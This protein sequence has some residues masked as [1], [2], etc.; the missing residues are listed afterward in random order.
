MDIHRQYKPYP[1]PERKQL[2]EEKALHALLS[3]ISEFRNWDQES[4]VEVKVNADNTASNAILVPAAQ[5]IFPATDETR[6]LFSSM[7]QIAID[8]YY[9]YS[10]VSK[11]FY[12]QAQFMKDF[13]DDYS[14]QE[15]FFSYYPHYQTMGYEHLRTYFTWRT[16]VRKGNVTKTSVSYAF[17]YIYELINNIGV[18]DPQAGFDKLIS[19]WQTFRYF[20]L[21]IEKY[22]LQWI[23][24]YFIYYPLPYSFKEFVKDHRLQMHYPTALGYESG[25]HESFDLYSGISKYNIK[26]SIFYGG[27]TH[28]ILRDCFYF[29]LN[30]L[31]TLSG[32]KNKCFEDFIFYPMNKETAWTPF[33][34]ALFY[35]VFKQT[36]RQVVFS[37][38]EAYI[39]HQNHWVYTTSILTDHGRQLI[40]YIMKEME[41]NLR[42]TFKFKYK[43]KA[44]LNLCDN[45]TLKKLEQMKI[46][47]PRVI[48]QC[49]AEFYA[50]YT[51]KEISVDLSNLMKIREEAQNIQEKLIIPEDSEAFEKEIIRDEITSSLVGSDIWTNFITELTQMEFEALTIILQSDDIKSFA[52]EKG[53]ML[54]VLLDG[55]N[56]KA[57]D[58]IG[59][60]ILCIEGK[61]SIYDDYIEKLTELLK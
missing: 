46:S 19:F 2:P 35:P 28:E 31:R 6:S 44:D 58:C 4:F 25:Q 15:P 30:R 60:T 23:K 61:V 50:F 24:D 17:L 49:V 1:I 51:R 56:E 26:K 11:I 42:E 14:K 37:E 52:R 3:P 12:Q 33:S 40:G 54:E 18:S 45:K 48:K 22:V 10:N 13:E 21:V 29:I 36:D 47:L 7:R 8:N 32:N 20:N 5:K 57:A 16:N 43:L 41:A 34:R 9:S 53:V 59:D 27:Q 39:C 38:K 55:I